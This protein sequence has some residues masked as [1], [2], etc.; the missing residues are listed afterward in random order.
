MG[1]GGGG[2]GDKTTFHYPNSQ[3]PSTGDGVLGMKLLLH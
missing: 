2:G 3:A 1:E